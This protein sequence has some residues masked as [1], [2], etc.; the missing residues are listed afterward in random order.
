MG[1]SQDVVKKQI[2]GMAMFDLSDNSNSFSSPSGMFSVYSKLKLVHDYLIKNNIE[3]KI[4]SED[5]VYGSGVKE[6][7]RMELGNLNF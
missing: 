3:T 1:E 5:V 6:V 7:M 4:Q 2:E